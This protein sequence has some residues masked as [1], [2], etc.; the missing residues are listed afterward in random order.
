MPFANHIFPKDEV[1]ILHLPKGC[2]ISKP[3]DLWVLHMTLHGLCR[4]P[5]HWYQLIKKILL[6]MG[7][8]MSPCDPYVF[9]GT[10]R[11]DLPPI[12]IGLYVD[13]FKYFLLSEETEDLFE[14]N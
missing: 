8:N 4:S 3:G 1:I 13:D 6:G 11:E 2:P 9:S 7:L 5:Y 12:Y 14:N 10:L